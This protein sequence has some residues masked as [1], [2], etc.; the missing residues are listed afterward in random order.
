MVLCTLILVS[1]LFQC[2]SLKHKLKVE[3]CDENHSSG[4]NPEWKADKCKSRWDIFN[5]KAVACNFNVI[6]K[7]NCLLVSGLYDVRKANELF[8]RISSESRTYN[9]T[10]KTVRGT[11]SLL[12]LYGGSRKSNEAFTIGIFPNLTSDTLKD[13]FFQANDTIS[14]S[15]NQSYSQVRLALQE[16]LY[17]GNVR[18]ISMFYYKCPSDTAEL[19][20]FKEEAAP[21][22]SASPRE[23]KGSCTNNTI[24][25]NS[26]LTMRCY[27]NG[28]FE[29]F[30]SCE[31]KAGFTNLTNE[32]KG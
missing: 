26:P 22:K 17:C 8:I 31:C 28:T 29:V 9:S 25:N 4:L 21:N 10:N 23:V 13:E 12:A 18:S 14:F 15:R 6:T 5:N 3:N 7:E 2:S 20:N 32:C 27:F 1:L 11:F 19:V 24:Q 30:G 16:S